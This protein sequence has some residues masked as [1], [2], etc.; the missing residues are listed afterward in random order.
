MTMQAY[1][2]IYLKLK[3]FKRPI[4]FYL[5]FVLKN[6]VR[7]KLKDVLTFYMCCIVKTMYIGK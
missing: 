4:L 6:F 3:H 7:F 2:S 1:L 5:T